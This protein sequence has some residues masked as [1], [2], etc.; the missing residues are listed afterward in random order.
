M[1]VLGKQNDEAARNEPPAGRASASEGLPGY[2]GRRQ[3]LPGDGMTGRR[4]PLAGVGDESPDQILIGGPRL[5][6]L[7]EDAPVLR[8]L[9][10]APGNLANRE[11][12]THLIWNSA[13]F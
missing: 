13:T 4:L 3:D 9:G 11:A 6:L 8:V 2:A 12:V 10:K 5:D 1:S 7:R